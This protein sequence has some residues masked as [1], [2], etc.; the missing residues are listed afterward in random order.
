MKV[1]SI[2]ILWVDDDSQ[3]AASKL[4]Q[5]A[6][7]EVPGCIDRLGR[8]EYSEH[9]LRYWHPA[10]FEPA[11]PETVEQDYQRHEALCRGEWSYQGCV[12]RAVVSYQIEGGDRRIDYLSSGG[13]YGV[14]SDSAMGFLLDI[15]VSQLLDLKAHLTV[16]GVP[17]TL[18]EE[19]ILQA[20]IAKMTAT[21]NE[22]LT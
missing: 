19:N 20:T 17:W 16:F 14:D 18:S 21:K 22:A 13:F 4:G 9:E 8:P 10:N 15:E 12:A 2:E 7:E 3:T 5:Y 1:E 6:S 11:H